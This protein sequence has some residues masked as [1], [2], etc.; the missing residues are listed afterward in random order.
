MPSILSA[1][2][3]TEEPDDGAW[4]VDLVAGLAF[5]S[6]ELLGQELGLEVRVL[7]LLPLV[8]H[9]FAEEADVVARDRGR[10]RVV[11]RRVECFGKSTGV[12][13]ARHVGSLALLHP[14]GHVVERR[15]VEHV[16]Y[17]VAE[18]LDPVGGQA[19][20][21]LADISRE[22]DEL[23]ASRRPALV[24]QLPETRFRPGQDQRVDRLASANER[25]EQMFS[26]EAAGSGHEIHVASSGWARGRYPRWAPQGNTLRSNMLIRSIVRKS[27]PVF[28]DHVELRR[29]RP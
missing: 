13:R 29:P 4:A 15:E 24:D 16:L 6:D 12:P 8:E 19:A 1:C 27:R 14:R 17:L 26:D 18:L 23:R 11:Q 28:A 2:P 20:K 21:R 22:H 5:V 9:V 10:A 25:V 7:V 3:S